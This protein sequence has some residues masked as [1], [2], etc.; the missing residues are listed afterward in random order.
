MRHALLLLLWRT[1][2]HAEN[3]VP[4]LLFALFTF[5]LK[6]EKREK[7]DCVGK[8]IIGDWGDNRVAKLAV[9]FYSNVM[10]GAIL[11]KATNGC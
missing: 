11:Y 10:Q 9:S 2:V 4:P 3:T 8:I 7:I 1:V 6:R 5:G